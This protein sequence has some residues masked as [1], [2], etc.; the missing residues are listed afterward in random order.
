M[1][2]II[3]SAY[4][5]VMSLITFILYGVDKG[6]AKKGKW[7]ISEKVLLLFPVF[8]GAIGGLLGMSI[9]RHK[10]KHWYFVLINVLFALI[11]IALLA[12]LLYWLKK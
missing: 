11:Y 10:T 7:R 1:W 3:Y 12:F 6:K 9:F 2:L 5:G 4:I 8:G